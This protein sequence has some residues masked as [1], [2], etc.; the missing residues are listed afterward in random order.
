M[1]YDLPK[2][3]RDGKARTLGRAGPPPPGAEW[4][5]W[6]QGR[7][8]GRTPRPQRQLCCAGPL[9]LSVVPEATRWGSSSV[10]GPGRPPAQEAA[11]APGGPG[12]AGSSLFV[13]SGSS[14]GRNLEITSYPVLSARDCGAD[15][16]GPR[17]CL[18][19]RNGRLLTRPSPPRA[20]AGAGPRGGVCR[21]GPCAVPHSRHVPCDARVVPRL[22]AETPSGAGHAL[23][24]SRGR[25]AAPG[26]GR[27]LRVLGQK[28][29][30]SRGHVAGPPQGAGLPFRVPSLLLGK[31][32]MPR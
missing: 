11:G 7:P 10:R 1:F 20:A 14:A 15:R 26:P 25:P 13:R 8:H 6:G 5:A 24:L 9:L 18:R 31:A 23:A 3:G 2:R 28:A 19:L 30:E 16:H 4:G 27:W 22:A 32:V 12:Q 21:C 17:F 29:S